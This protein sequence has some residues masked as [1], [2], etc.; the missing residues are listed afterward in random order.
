[1]IKTRTVT[2]NTTRPLREWP[3]ELTRTERSWI[4]RPE[5]PLLPR[6]VAAY[7][8]LRDRLHILTGAM[9][10]PPVLSDDAV[11]ATLRLSLRRGHE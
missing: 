2:R 1:M 6:A 3:A 9:P 4:M 11:D 8:F 7:G 10:L 5:C